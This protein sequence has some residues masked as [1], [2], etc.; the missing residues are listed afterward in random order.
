MQALL[1]KNIPLANDVLDS[2]VDLTELWSLC[3][4]ANENSKISNLA[5][6]NV[7][8]IIDSL[9]QIQQ[10]IHEIANISI[11]RTEAADARTYTPTTSSKIKHSFFGKNSKSIR[12]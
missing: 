2:S 8:R 4:Q 12:S 11:D 3:L 10:D 5:L 9:D 1:S 7:R 6:V